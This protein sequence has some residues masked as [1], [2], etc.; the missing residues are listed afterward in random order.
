MIGW[1]V[2][3]VNPW[4]VIKQHHLLIADRAVAHLVRMLMP[5]KFQMSQDGRYLIYI[6]KQHGQHKE[7]VFLVQTD[8]NKTGT[9]KQTVVLA[10]SAYIAPDQ[11][12]VLGQGY[13]YTGVQGQNDYQV[14]QFGQY[15]LS[16]PKVPLTAWTMDPDAVASLATLWSHYRQPY[17]AA[18]LQWRLLVTLTPLCLAVV[19]VVLSDLQP[20]RN[21]YLILAP[22]TLIY[23]I[24]NN[25]LIIAKRWVENSYVSIGVG[26]WW[27]PALC[28]CC[29][30]LLTQTRLIR[31]YVST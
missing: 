9:I 31:R 29:L 17:Q 8:K 16:L 19:A 24:Y 15:R 6:E 27:V 20:R 11:F 5:G 1:L 25:L 12:F 4:A 22:A 21:R 26:M 3:W 10:H 7:R 28:L 14:T 18:E 2:F 30:I 13:R 23:I